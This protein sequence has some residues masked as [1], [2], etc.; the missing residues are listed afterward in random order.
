MSKLRQERRALWN[1]IPNLHIVGE[2][3]E[4]IRIR[5]RRMVLVMVH[6]H[7]SFQQIM[8]SVECEEIAGVVSLPC[9]NYFEIQELFMS[10]PPTHEYLFIQLFIRFNDDGI[11]SDKNTVRVWEHPH[12]CWTEDYP[13]FIPDASMVGWMG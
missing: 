5:C 1:S 4:R 3:I 10:Q 8:S 7:L 9:C 2:G 13:Q 12:I 11:W 6:C